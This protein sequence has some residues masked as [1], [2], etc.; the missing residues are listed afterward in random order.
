MLR[1]IE[2]GFVMWRLAECGEGWL[3]VELAL[4]VRNE[5]GCWGSWGDH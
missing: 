2:T 1:R 5:D 3:E 4:E